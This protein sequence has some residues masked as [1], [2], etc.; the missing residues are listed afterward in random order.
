M[1]ANSLYYHLKPYLPWRLRMGLR[2]MIARRNREKYT[3][4]WPINEAAGQAPAGWP[5][6]PDGK[7]FALV[8]THDVEGPAGLAKCRQLMELEQKLGF[9]SSFN[10]IPEGDYAVSRELREELTKNG[11]EVGVH[12]LHHNGKLYQSRRVFSENARWINHY[13]KEWGATGFR[14]GFMLRQMNWL[15]DLDIQYDTSTFD[16]D[17]FEPQP[18]GAGTIFPFWVPR[19]KAESGKQNAECG[20]GKFAQHSTLNT[21]HSTDLYQSEIGNRKPETGD[22]YIELPYTLPQDSTL[23]LVLKEKST[24]IWKKKLDW[25]AQRG[26]M[27]LVNVHP[28]YLGF[29]ERKQQTAE[30]PA[31]WYKEFLQ[32]IQASYGGKIWNALPCESA[33]WYK[34]NCVPRLVLESGASTIQNAN[35]G[36]AS[37]NGQL[38]LAGKNVGVVIFS[39]YLS[40]PRPRR[41]AEIL[42]RHGAGVEV[43]CLQANQ[44]KPRYDTVNGVKIHRVPLKRQR[45]GKAS[46]IYQY[47]AFTFAAL[48]LLAA[49]SFR[50][51]YHLIHVHNMPDVLV[52]S[53]LIPKILGAKVI[54][55]LHD[56]MPELMLTIFKLPPESF[57]VRM[58]K[59]FEK[60][61]T[62]FADVVLTV[63]LASKRIYSSRSCVPEKIRIVMNSPNEDVF[64]FRPPSIPARNGKPGGNFTI[65]YHGS[66]LQRNGFDLAV[67]ALEAV[68]K[69]IPGAALVVC[70]ERTPFFDSVM[71]NASERGLQNAINY[72]GLKKAEQ[73]AEAIDRCDLGIIP[74]HR[75]IFTEMNTPTRIFEY[76]SR[77][78]PVI[79][80]RAR[81][82]QDYFAEQDLIYFE[83]GNADDLARKIEYAYFHP[84]E[85]SE[86]VERG[87]KVY[88]THRWSQESLGFVDTVTGLLGTGLKDMGT[89]SRR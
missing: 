81:G 8:L 76:L 27:A 56:P 10:F 55:D 51:R 53:A 60:W 31:V 26:G 71:A 88:L 6:W 78:K 20:N 66:L 18:D 39:H 9:R 52:F 25:I 74:N 67:K 83:L 63:N 16:T 34:D 89:K 30:Y 50:K 28:D 65:M 45:G 70:G 59:R 2:R 43:I 13:L 42:A 69:S 21:Q 35:H 7:K 23:F 68:K 19:P 85:V 41:S 87:Q 84:A 14:S 77:G 17:P 54:L 32:H 5:G 38:S 64:Q 80:P 82:I 33:R 22:G 24:A 73:I 75:N 4:V 11:F 3:D 1:S 15:H 49:R 62:G 36:H 48:I 72:L 37:A 47:S 61:S 86:T 44:A 29:N 58:L 46:Y 79:T 12:D 40:D 57:S